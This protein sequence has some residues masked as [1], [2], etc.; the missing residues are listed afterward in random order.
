MLP[1]CRNVTSGPYRGRAV[2]LIT[3]DPRYHTA[4]GI[5]VGSP[6]SSIEAT[7]RCYPQ[8]QT[9]GDATTDDPRAAVMCVDEEDL[10]PLGGDLAGPSY[11][12]SRGQMRIYIAD[13]PRDVIRTMA[14]SS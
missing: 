8:R 1:I 13:G 14:A 7:A 3:A 11:T 12:A 6:T 2:G 9:D 5:G 10:A 4:T